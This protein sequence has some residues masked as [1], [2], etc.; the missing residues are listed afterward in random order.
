MDRHLKLAGWMLPQ[1]ANA[2]ALLAKEVP[3]QRL[4]TIVMADPTVSPQDKRVLLG[5]IEPKPSGTTRLGDYLPAIAGA[6]L[7]AMG[8]ALTAP[9][10]GLSGPARLAYGIGATAL[11]AV[12]NSALPVASSGTFPRWKG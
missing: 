1:Q 12:L 6:G 8:A 2:A 5:A 3:V 9:L 11:G 4:V 10:F 7:G